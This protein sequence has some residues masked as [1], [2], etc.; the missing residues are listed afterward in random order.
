[1]IGRNAQPERINLATFLYLV[2]LYLYY[3]NISLLMKNPQNL[4][5]S[6]LEGYFFAYFKTNRT[7]FITEPFELINPTFSQVPK[8]PRVTRRLVYT[9]WTGFSLRH[10]LGHLHYA[11]FWATYNVTLETSPCHLRQIPPD[12]SASKVHNRT[13]PLCSAVLTT[14]LLM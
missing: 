1:M 8:R 6:R 11:I 12:F 3:R 14:F 7:L 9:N 4:D 10:L 5:I 13:V 2:S